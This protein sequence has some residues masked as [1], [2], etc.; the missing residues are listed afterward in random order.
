MKLTINQAL[1]RCAELK[2]KI[3]IEHQWLEAN[4]Y[5]HGA[6]PYAERGGLRSEVAACFERIENMTD[7]LSRL[8]VRVHT[9][10][11]E[12]QIEINGQRRSVAEWIAWRRDIAGR[13]MRTVHKMRDETRRLREECRKAQVGIV[14]ANPNHRQMVLALDEPAVRERETKTQ[15]TLHK[16]K[17]AMRDINNTTYIEVEA[18]QG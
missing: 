11:A 5:V 14:N 1:D 18:A 10:N 9:K 15:L 12:T 3:Q 16:L 8:S 2:N 6:D 7:E 13:F 17:C 4:T